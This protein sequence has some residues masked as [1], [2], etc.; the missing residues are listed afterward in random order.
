MKDDAGTEAHG[1]EWRRALIG[2]LI[3]VAFGALIGL[4]SRRERTTRQ[5]A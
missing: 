4:L 1:S 5:L 3:G 2:L